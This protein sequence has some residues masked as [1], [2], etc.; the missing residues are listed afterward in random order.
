MLKSGDLKDRK[1]YGRL[2]SDQG[3]ENIIFLQVIKSKNEK[4]RVPE[5]ILFWLRGEKKIAEVIETGKG[6]RAEFFH[7]TTDFMQGFFLHFTGFGKEF[8]R[9][10]NQFFFRRFRQKITAGQGERLKF[11][12]VGCQSRSGM[13]FADPCVDFQIKMILSCVLTQHPGSGKTMGDV[14]F[15]PHTMDLRGMTMADPDIVQHCAAT[16]YIRIQIKNS[17]LRRGKKLYG[18]LFDLG[19]VQKQDL[20]QRGVFRIKMKNDFFSIYLHI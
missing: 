3:E 18:F 20:S 11:D 14:M 13:A 5:N 6:G 2:A 17:A 15:C 8:I 19:T 4:I 12:L 16:D 1:N 7:G 10:T 9:K